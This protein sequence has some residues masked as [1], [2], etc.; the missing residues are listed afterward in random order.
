MSKFTRMTAID[1]TDTKPAEST[2]GRQSMDAVTEADPTKEIK[3][4]GPLSEVYTKALQIV[5]A[6]VEPES[7]M[8][9]VESAANDTLMQIAL[10]KAATVKNA[11]VYNKTNL[12]NGY[13]NLKN[14]NIYS[15]YADDFNA[16]K[17]IDVTKQLLDYKNIHPNTRNIVVLD[18]GETTTGEFN[19][20]FDNNG[21]TVKAVTE[22]ICKS[23]GIE[24]YYNFESLVKHL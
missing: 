11:E 13:R 16:G 5:Y 3:M 21:L 9:A 2:P 24:L 17:V 22:S 6:K 20:A 7:G 19:K 1:H 12:P 4:T 18:G 10:R 23:S 15:G 8:M 14:L